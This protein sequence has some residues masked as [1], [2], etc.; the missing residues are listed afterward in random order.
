MAISDRFKGMKMGTKVLLICMVLVIVPVSLLGVVAYTSSAAAIEDQ[1]DE[2][3]SARIPDINKMAQNT[4]ELSIDSLDA[5]LSTLRY[6]F[7][8]RGTP[9]IVD[10]QLVLQG[11]E[12]NYVVNDNYEI[13]DEITRMTGAKA[14]IFQKV[15]DQAVRVSTNVI[16]SDGTRAVGTT[17]SR[18]VYEA[19][20]NRGET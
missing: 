17:V 15:G 4:Y 12:G 7:L 2:M 3:V 9:A 20:I 13:V 5:Q 10:G 14:T 8:S 6:L 19:V 16:K 18:P 11:P 1:V